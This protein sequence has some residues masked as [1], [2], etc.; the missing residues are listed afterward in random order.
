M[1]TRHISEKSFWKIL[2]EG[3]LKPLLES[4]KHDDTLELEL[5]GN[6]VNIYYR[7]GSLFKI[8]KRTNGYKIEFNTKYCI[9]PSMILD[10]TPSAEV[11]VRDIPLYKQA[12][13]WYF[14]AHPK[15]EREF[16]QVIVRENNNHG[17]ISGGYTFCREPDEILTAIGWNRVG[18]HVLKDPILAGVYDLSMAAFREMAD[19]YDVHCPGDFNTLYGEGAVD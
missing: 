13:D 9:N 17:K 14:H 5:R 19:H 10:G 6:A 1:K 8:N 7:G 16:Q 15:Y 12:M 4:V 3:E 2:T 18:M 11:A